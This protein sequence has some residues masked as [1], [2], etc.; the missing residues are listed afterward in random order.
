MVKEGG[1]SLRPDIRK[2]RPNY[3]ETDEVPVLI[4]TKPTNKLVDKVP[5]SGYGQMKTAKLNVKIGPPGK[6]PHP[7]GPRDNQK[8]DARVPDKVNKP[9]VKQKVSS[10]VEDPVDIA[11]PSTSRKDTSKKPVTKEVKVTSEMKVLTDNNNP[12]E[13]RLNILQNRF[14]V[15]RWKE[16]YAFG[17]PSAMSWLKKSTLSNISQDA[18]KALKSKGFEEIKTLE[19]LFSIVLEV[20]KKDSRILVCPGEELIITDNFCL[21]EFS[22]KIR[23][24]L[25][26][27]FTDNK[28]KDVV[29]TLIMPDTNRLNNIHYMRTVREINNRLWTI[30]KNYENMF[31]LDLYRV[32]MERERIEN[33]KPDRRNLVLPKSNG[34]IEGFPRSISKEEVESIDLEFSDIIQKI[35]NLPKSERIKRARSKQEKEEASLIDNT[36]ANERASMNVP[37][38]NLVADENDSEDFA[39]QVEALAQANAESILYDEEESKDPEE[40]EEATNQSDT[41]NDPTVDSSQETQ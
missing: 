25:T 16:F 17:G 20:A 28:V 22:L 1:R 38:M 41:V 37:T 36:I 40:S 12:E 34:L 11:Q 32:C 24:F 26:S 5:S 30:R 15:P 18:S 10:T 6:T 7:T 33:K 23:K 35:L 4:K 14:Q 31:V 29:I 39:A 13:A 3:D 19:E 21:D 8:K 27:L 2:N 9:P